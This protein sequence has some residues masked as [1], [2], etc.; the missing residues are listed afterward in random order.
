MLTSVHFYDEP[1]LEAYE[2]NDV[3]AYRRLSAKLET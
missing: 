3:R 2:I 1:I